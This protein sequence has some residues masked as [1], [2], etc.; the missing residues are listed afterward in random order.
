M[1][2][3]DPERLNSPIPTEATTGGRFDKH[4]VQKAL[5]Q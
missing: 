4:C 3:R 1:V 5:N 2:E